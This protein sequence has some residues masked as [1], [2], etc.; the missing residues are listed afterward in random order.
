MVPTVITVMDIASKVYGAASGIAQVMRGRALCNQIQSLD[1]AVRDLT[2]NLIYLPER[3]AV[4]DGRRQQQLIIEDLGQVER[5]LMPVQRVF[6][7][8]IASSAL[9]ETPTAL[10]RALTSDPFDVLIDTKPFEFQNVEVEH[11]LAQQLARGYVG[12]MFA[13]KGQSYLGWQKPGVLDEVFNTTC[14]AT[15]KLWLPEST[16]STIHC[17]RC[18][19]SLPKTNLVRHVL[20]VHSEELIQCPL[21]ECPVNVRGKNFLVHVKNCHAKEKLNLEDLRD[22]CPECGASVRCDNLNRHLEQRCP[23]RKNRSTR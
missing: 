15:S 3:L 4:R 5:A 12:V 1:E 6:D 2:S 13:Y 20:C 23:G 14:D 22:Q 11:A 19:T 9:I 8:S 16:V 17:G 10:R 21:C 18:R 7:C